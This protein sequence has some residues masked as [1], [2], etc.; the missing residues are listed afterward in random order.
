M[1]RHILRVAWMIAAW[2]YAGLPDA[3]AG[4]MVLISNPVIT[5]GSTGLVEVVLKAES[6]EQ[7]DAAN[8]VFHLTPV[9]ATTGSLVFTDPQPFRE[10]DD[11]DYVFFGDSSGIS[12]T[13][14]PLHVLDTT[15]LEGND[16]TVSGAGR[17]L[18]TGEEA[19]LVRLELQHIAGPGGPIGGDLFEI[20]LE[21]AS[22]TFLLDPLG[23]EIS[24]NPA[25]FFSAQISIA[26]ATAVPEPSTVCGLT[27]IIA[28]LSMRLRRKRYN[29]L[30]D[31]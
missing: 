12:L 20:S 8:Y 2:T 16:L 4:V 11:S 21:N 9:G 23:N 14:D 27:T 28:A 25:S 30:Q 13:V 7:I 1:N 31:A 18:L 24:L 15:T 26:S 5:A 22:G 3:R 29:P 6:D 19:L 10:T 17:T